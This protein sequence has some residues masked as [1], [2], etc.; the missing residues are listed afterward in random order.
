MRVCLLNDSFPPVIDGVA[1]AVENY[2]RI[3][4]D[5]P[6]G[7][8]VAT[9]EYPNAADER[10][11]PVIRYPSLNTT[12]LVGYRTG[13]PLD[14]HT[15][16]RLQGE[17]P[18]LIHSHCPVM[19]GVLARV[20]RELCDAPIVFTY[21]TKFDVD[22]QNA[23]RF[24]VLQE[25]AIR[26]L[27][28]NV[29][30]CDE[31]WVV[32]GGAGENLRSLGYQGDYRIMPNGVDLPRGRLP[33][34]QIR[35][36]T[37]EDQGDAA[38]LYLFVGRLMWYKGIRLILDGLRALR[39]SGKAFRLVFIGR[40]RDE[41][42]I[43]RYVTEL[44]LE[45]C[46]SFLGAVYDRE[47]LRAWYCRADLL[48][49]PSAFD[50]NGLVVREAAACSLP[51][52]LISGSCAAEGIK[53]GETG[54]LIEENA[55]ALAAALSHIG[56]D[57]ELLSRVGQ[58]AMGQIYLSWD[59]SVHAALL[60]YEQVLETWNKSGRDRRRRT[61]TDERIANIGG[62]AQTLEQTRTRMREYLTPGSSTE[63]NTRR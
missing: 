17:Q 45:D 35:L 53:D 46:C 9:P 21:H 10:P 13:L 43:R 47:T 42:D 25:A 37:G 16:K 56:C 11:Y 57:R 34:E 5:Q 6:G 2:A 12:H 55:E 4:N 8:L 20:L 52:L 40:G 3:L 54:F 59:D 60:R 28:D 30:A 15:L 38:P 31:V 49:F 41:A 32:S 26:L 7:C 19:S 18:D 51:A 22:I 29:E 24:Q 61:L 63:D 23:V 39:A 27:V 33:E 36:L 1:N 62:L 50:T 44:G 58:N 14:P 48:L